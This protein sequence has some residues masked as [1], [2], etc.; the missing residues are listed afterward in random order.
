MVCRY[1]SEYFIGEPYARLLTAD[2]FKFIA[3]P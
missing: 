2:L 3:I 1:D